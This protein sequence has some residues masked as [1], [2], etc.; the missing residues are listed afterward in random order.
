MCLLRF[1]ML[2][3]TKRLYATVANCITKKN[4]SINL[5]KFLTFKKSFLCS[6][7]VDK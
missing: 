7:H 1:M 5:L 3:Y 4:K 2:L 6:I